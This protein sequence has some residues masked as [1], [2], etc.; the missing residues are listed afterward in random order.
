MKLPQNVN[1]WDLRHDS[2]HS[3]GGNSIVSGRRSHI[4]EFK[5]TESVERARTLPLV[6]LQRRVDDVFSHVEHVLGVVVSCWG[7]CMIWLYDTTC[8]A[9]TNNVS[10]VLRFFCC[11]CFMEKY[12]RRRFLTVLGVNRYTGLFVEY[13]VKV[14]SSPCTFNEFARK[15]L[16][17]SENF[18]YFF[19]KSGKKKLG[20]F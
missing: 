16:N 10:F 12:L 3:E 6:C 8:R 19:I 2:C 18:K 7:C 20:T 13:P 17:Q 14:F 1:Q 4:K 15:I 5:V 9:L 11:T